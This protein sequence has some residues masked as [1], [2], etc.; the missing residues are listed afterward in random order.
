MRFQF[1]PKDSKRFWESVAQRERPDS[2]WLWTRRLN[3]NGYGVFSFKGHPYTAHRVS[4]SLHHG[5]VPDKLCVCHTCD[6]RNCVNPAHLFVG[7]VRDNNRDAQ[8][9]GR[10]YRRG[11]ESYNAKLTDAQVVELRERYASG[12]TVKQLAVAFGVVG[13]HVCS[14]GTGSL[15]PEAGGP[16][17]REKSK[18]LSDAQVTELRERYAAGASS[19]VLA[20]EYGICQSNVTLIAGG[21][22][23]R[24]AGGPITRRGRGRHGPL[25]G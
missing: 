24:G 20:A 19:T 21:K 1:T 12:E 14:L 4:Y 6:V 3:R 9:K 17:T 25:R 11:Q 23:R 16:F 13:T 10:N 22:S 2:C 18:K 15:R 8:E 5:E 7:T